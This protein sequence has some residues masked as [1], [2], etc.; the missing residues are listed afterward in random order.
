VSKVRPALGPIL[1]G[2]ALTVVGSAWTQRGAATAAVP[3][4][5]W[6]TGFKPTNLKVLRNDIST[7]DIKRLMHRYEDALG[8][9]CD[10]CHVENDDT[11]QL[12]YA[13]D[14]NPKKQTARLMIAM[15]NDINDKYLAQL[16]NGDYGTPVTCGNC[17]QGQ[18]TPP[19]FDPRPRSEGER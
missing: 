10:Y 16:G 1:V 19:A 18:T 9:S 2:I 17:H 15:L 7:A 8:V 11:K 14:D 12:D 6:E 4:V 13:S 3:S 5:T